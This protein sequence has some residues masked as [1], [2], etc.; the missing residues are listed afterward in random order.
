MTSFSSI[1]S[2]LA[3]WEV[4]EYAGTAI[5]LV[6]VVGELVAEHDWPSNELKRKRLTRYSTWILVAGLAIEAVALARSNQL[7]GRL[8]AELH[9]EA[10]SAKA[11]AKGF[12]RNMA[13]ANER[14]AAAHAEAAKATEHVQAAERD[15]ARSLETAEKERLERVRLEATISPRRLSPEQRAAI[16]NACRRFAGR[17]VDVRSAYKNDLEAAVLARQIADSLAQAG[18]DVKLAIATHLLVDD[19]HIGIEITPTFKE[20]DIASAIAQSLANDG[21]L[22]NVIVTQGLMADETMILVGV[23]PIKE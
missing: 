20:F 10:E 4:A 21:K 23:K 14:I 3:F 6:G 9:R 17:K 13:G 1:E 12:E 15:A 22:E 18:L 7:A 5:V 8:I 16:V 11:T 19:M 2:L